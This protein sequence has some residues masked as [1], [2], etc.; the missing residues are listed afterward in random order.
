MSAKEW[1]GSLIARLSTRLALAMVGLVLLTATSMAILIYRNIEAIAVPRALER[2]DTRARLIAVELEASVRGARADVSTQGRVIDALVSARAAG[3]NHPLDGA[4]EAQLRDRLASRFISELK[5]KPAYSKYRLIGVADGGREIVRVDRMGA[6]GTIRVV[7][8]SELLRKGDREFFKETIRLLAGEVYA[9]PIDFSQDE[10]V[11]ELPHVPTLRVA[12]P[13]IAADGKPFGILVI[14]VDLRTAFDRIRAARQASGAIYVVNE[15]GDFLVHPDTARE[16]GFEFGKPMRLQDDF[17]KLT[18]A[19]TANQPEARVVR[20][21]SGERFGVAM[22]P[23]RLVDSRKVF[24]VDS[25]P[26]SAIVANAAAT[27]RDSTLLAGLAAV[28]IA[29]AL[30][31][32]IARSLSQPLIQITRSVEGFSRGNPIIVPRNAKGEI[33]VLARAFVQMAADLRDRT[34]ALNSEMER[35]RRIFDSSLDLILVVDKRGNFVQVSPSSAEI[36]GHR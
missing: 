10:G 15:R 1:F 9:S 14:N 2:M 5:V 11:V 29:I 16:F 27:V 35:H 3:G 20:D 13:V 32:L 23:I 28:L 19:L 33:G 31:L 30:A 26:Y 34:T 17:P 21:V 22:A 24:V 36:L 4:S 6:D 7:P 18:E 12:A 8:D 25:V